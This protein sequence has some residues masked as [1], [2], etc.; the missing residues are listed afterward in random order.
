MNK[1]DSVVHKAYLKQVDYYFNNSRSAKLIIAL[2]NLGINYRLQNYNTQLNYKS[3][4][5]QRRREN[6]IHLFCY[7]MF[8]TE[9]QFKNYLLITTNKFPQKLL[10]RL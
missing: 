1:Q 5:K 4:L 6:Y 9:F 8:K 2:N 7:R 10:S 3:M